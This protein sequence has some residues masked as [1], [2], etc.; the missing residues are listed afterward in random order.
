VVANRHHEELSALTDV[1]QV[2]FAQEPFAAGILQAIE[3]YVFFHIGQEE[4]L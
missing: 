4:K 1:G 2:F 3:H